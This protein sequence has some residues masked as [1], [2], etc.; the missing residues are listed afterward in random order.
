MTD[1]TCRCAHLKEEPRE[2][3]SRPGRKSLVV[4]PLLLICERLTGTR[5]ETGLKVGLAGGFGGGLR[6]FGAA[7]LMTF[8]GATF[9][10]TFL[11]AA[12]FTTFLGAA[13]GR[14]RAARRQRE[15]CA[16]E[17]VSA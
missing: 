9:L 5:A 6:D 15:Q 13:S 8:L 16:R 12:F 14:I 11:G 10:T 2:E 1:L 4:L 3:N 7:F 17:K